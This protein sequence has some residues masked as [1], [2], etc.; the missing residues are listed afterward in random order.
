MPWLHHSSEGS[1]SDTVGGK[2]SLRHELTLRLTRHS[3][4]GH[5]SQDGES[6]RMYKG[7][8]FE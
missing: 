5:G 3:I 7:K 4:S 6:A 2:L 8:I 1:T